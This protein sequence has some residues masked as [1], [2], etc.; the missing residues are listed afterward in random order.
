M[1]AQQELR[2]TLHDK[3]R[4]KEEIQEMRQKIQDKK[5][6]E[7]EYRDLQ[8]KIRGHMKGRKKSKW[9]RG[10]SNTKTAPRWPATTSSGA[11]FLTRLA[12]SVFVFT[13]YALVLSV[14]CGLVFMVNLQTKARTPQPDLY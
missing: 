7:D 12:V 10:E 14:L 8:E 6:L 2:N 4:L 1:F 13:C 5:E 9:S 11:V 3:W